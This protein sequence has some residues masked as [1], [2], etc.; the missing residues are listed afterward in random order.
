MI[1]ECQRMQLT[2][3]PPDVNASHYEFAV[4]DQGEIVYKGELQ[5]LVKGLLLKLLKSV[6]KAVL[7]KTCLILCPRI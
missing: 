3:L 7:L 5:G 4:N 6:R 2:L 1:D